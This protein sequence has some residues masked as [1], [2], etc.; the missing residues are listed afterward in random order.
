[1]TPEKRYYTR[2]FL[3]LGLIQVALL[4]LLWRLNNLEYAGETNHN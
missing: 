3:K 2:F 4:A 1:M